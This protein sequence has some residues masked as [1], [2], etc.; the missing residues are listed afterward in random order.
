ML[1]IAVNTIKDN[2]KV[3]EIIFL[4]IQSCHRVKG[5]LDENNRIQSLAK[6]CKIQVV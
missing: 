5:R 6:L 4:W 3:N 1:I 2:N